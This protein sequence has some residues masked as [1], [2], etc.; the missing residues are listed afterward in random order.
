[1][2]VMSDFEYPQPR[3]EASSIIIYNHSHLPKKHGAL[4]WSLYV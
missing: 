4:R 3:L 1:M 2:C